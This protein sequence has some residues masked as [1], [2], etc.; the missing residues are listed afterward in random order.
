M[1]LTETTKTQNK[2]YDGKII[3]LFCD[4]IYLPNGEEAKREFVTHTG[5]VTILPIDDDN[6]VYFVR[7]FRY[8]YKAEL[9]EL[10]AG[11]KEAGEDPCECGMREL[12]EEIGATA[13][14][15]TPLAQMYPSP[16]YTNEVIHIYLAKG[17]SFSDLHLDEDE[18]LNVEKYPLETAIE[19][20]MNGE[21]KDGKTIIGILKYA[22]KAKL[23]N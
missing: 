18:F 4:E 2:L 11:K 1:K 7:Q 17:L 13:K 15:F 5:G 16:G 6:N 21:I 14:I 19:M 10:P 22:C 9:L 8:P 20:V 3:K 12:S 23:C